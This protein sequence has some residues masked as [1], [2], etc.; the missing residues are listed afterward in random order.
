MV[1]RQRTGSAHSG[2]GIQR[3]PSSPV[4]VWGWLEM[5]ATQRLRYAGELRARCRVAVLVHGVEADSAGMSVVTVGFVPDPAEDL[6]DSGG[7]GDPDLEDV[8]NQ[9]RPA[10]MSG[11]ASP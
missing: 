1:K 6:A 4:S 9:T 8:G 11:M 7:E 10:D 2:I 5:D 3:I